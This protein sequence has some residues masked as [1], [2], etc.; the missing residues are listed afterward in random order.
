[1]PLAAV[2]REMN[3]VWSLLGPVVARQRIGPRDGEVTMCNL[4]R[5]LLLALCVPLSLGAAEAALW[6]KTY[7]S[8]PG[9]GVFAGEPTADGGYIVVGSVQVPQ[10]G[11]D[12]DVWILKLDASGNVTWQQ[13]MYSGTSDDIARAVLPTADAGYVVTGRAALT[14]GFVL[15]VNAS[16]NVVWQRSYGAGEVWSLKSVRDGGYAVLV[17]TPDAPSLMKLD[18]A[19]NVI[20]QK[21]YPDAPGLYYLQ[22]TIEG[23]YVAAGFSMLSAESWVARVLKLD[24]DGN[25]AWHKTYGGIGHHVVESLH[26][27]SDG[28]YVLSGW[29]SP[30]PLGA[31]FPN[32]ID[33][34]LLRLDANGGIVWQ[35]AYGAGGYDEASSVLETDGGEYIAVGTTSSS[36]RSD[37]WA[38]KLDHAGNIVWQEKFLAETNGASAQFVRSTFDGGYF[39]GGQFGRDAWVAKMDAN[40]HID[41]CANLGTSAA[42]AV[43][44][45]ATASNGNATVLIGSATAASGGLSVRTAAMSSQQ[46]CTSSAPASGLRAIEYFHG[47]YGHYFVTAMSAEISAIDDGVFS[48]WTRTGQTFDVLA[49]NTKESASVCRFWSGQSY[50][51]KSSHFYTPLDWECAIVQHKRDWVFEGDIFA[52]RL[53]ESNGACTGG[54]TPL[55]R[56]FNNGMSG[57]PNHRYTTSLATRSQMIAQGWIAEGSGIGVIGCVP[58]Q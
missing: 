42:T 58:T 9:S 48:G 57:A 10:D 22:T 6:A 25:I 49:V 19:G 39:M 13:M 2:A 16:G 7:T 29:I 46:Q 51:P 43:N 4:F 21:V 11:G 38:L 18:A 50:A 15:K 12:V 40:G 24:Q 32:N 14:G 5:S 56:L 33:A 1:M 37:V 17:G 20:W 45:N 8:Y 52:T 47:A 36:G 30:A 35:K 34:W 55:Y 44:T 27:T 3:Q 41:G 53:P 28:G 26:S 23:G 31:E 54:M